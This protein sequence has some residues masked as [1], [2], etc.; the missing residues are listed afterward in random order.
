MS[1]CF[2]LDFFFPSKWCGPLFFLK[3]TGCA[4]HLFFFFFFIPIDGR[5]S[6]QHFP[7][8]TTTT[9]SFFLFFCLGGGECYSSSM[10]MCD[11]VSNFSGSGLWAGRLAGWADRC[12]CCCCPIYTDG[13][14]CNI[15]QIRTG[16]NWDCLSPRLYIITSSGLQDID[17]RDTHT[18]PC[19]EWMDSVYSLHASLC[20]DSIFN[21]TTDEAYNS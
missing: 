5:K 1:F 17:E 6:L 10:A 15:L 2:F 20:V 21:R 12:C 13:C 4:L 8:T 3:S 14:V 19:M 9:F 16:D 18:H 7:T 11:S